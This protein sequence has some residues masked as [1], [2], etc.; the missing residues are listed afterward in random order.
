MVFLKLSALVLTAIVLVPSA[1][2]LFEFAGKINL[3][4]QSYFT[5]QA[6][7][8]GWSMFA[9]PIFAAI[10]ANMLLSLVYWRRHDKRA[11]YSGLAAGLIAGSLAVFFV[12][13]FPGNQQTANWT[14]GPENW[15]RLRRNWEY[16]HAANAIIVFVAFIA[17]CLAS[18]GYRG[19]EQS[20][21]T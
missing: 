9:L 1:A 19:A 17:T 20:N 3:D 12:W 15:E 5:V 16:G 8:A 21:K 6:I 10:L 18:I 7:Y 2:H 13:V 4:R 14:S 11:I